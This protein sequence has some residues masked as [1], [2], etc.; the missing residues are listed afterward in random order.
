MF[1]KELTNKE[2]DDFTKKHKSSLY[3][4][5]EYAFT[6]NRH[7]FNSMFIGLVNEDEIIAATLLLIEKKSG[8]KYAYAPRGFI[9]DYSNFEL[10]K[11][12]TTEIKKLLYKKDI[13]AIKLCPPILKTSSNYDEIYNNL[14]KLGYWHFGYNYYF[15]ALKPR[16]EAVINIEKPYF[17]NFNNVKK[18]YKTKIRSAAKHGVNIYR[19]TKDDLH[20]LYDQ[21][22][23]KYIRDLKYFNDLYEFFGAEKKVEFYYAKLDTKYYLDL[24][25]T[26]FERI[27]E[28]NEIINL[29]VVDHRII[30][31]HKIINKKIESDAM[32]AEAK[33]DLIVA[34]NLLSKFPEG[35]IL[36]SALI[37]KNNDEIYLM[38][39]G[40]DK[41]YSQINAKHLLIWKIIEKY[42]N[43][44]FKTFN[45][46]GI[47]AP[48]NPGKYK[49]LNDFKLSFGA[50][51]CEYI[52]D[53]ELVINQPKYFMMKKA[54]PLTNILKK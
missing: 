41:H 29:K 27:E 46:G 7:D 32:L 2:F 44:E 35:I 3:Q 39:D 43:K 12:F 15:E 26:E 51:V 17:E 38:I 16:F 34:T 9:L 54:L 36:A 42:S 31:D 22:K 50:H 23:K 53:L 52:G 6:M 47:S 33:K 30:N 48:E 18:N 49:G 28:E 5:K 40:F 10:V 1:A 8:F 24:V 21:T 4:S 11:T 45:L 37:V 14:K 20:L 13:T 25:K 19:G